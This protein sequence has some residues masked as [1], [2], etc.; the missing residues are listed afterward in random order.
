MKPSLPRYNFTWNV[1]DLSKYLAKLEN[2]KLVLKQLTFK[3]S[4]LLALLTVQRLQSLH[5]ID[6]RNIAINDNIVKIRF[7]DLLKQSK[8]GQ[9]INEIILDSYVDK[10]L[11]VVITL[12]YLTGRAEWTFTFT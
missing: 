6:I 7:G 3:L 1:S 8:P 2:D 12:F 10:N 5:L 11:C 4:A 9:H